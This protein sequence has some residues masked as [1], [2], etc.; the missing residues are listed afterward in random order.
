[1]NHKARV[2]IFSANLCETFIILRKSKRNIII[3]TYRSSWKVH[4]ILVRF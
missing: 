2:F 4:V 1:M 3:N